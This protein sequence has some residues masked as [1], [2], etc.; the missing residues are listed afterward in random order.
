[1]WS[2]VTT[3]VT[4]NYSIGLS[5]AG[6]GLMFWGT[7]TIPEFKI[8]SIH[9]KDLKLFFNKPNKF[10]KKVLPVVD[11]QTLKILRCIRDIRTTME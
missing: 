11:S 2:S 6:F 10:Y 1:M 7:M 4:W 5:L 9:D 3:W 8:L